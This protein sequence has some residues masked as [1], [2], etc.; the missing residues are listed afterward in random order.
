MLLFILGVYR[1]LVPPVVTIASLSPSPG[2][3]RWHALVPGAAYRWVKKRRV[4]QSN[5]LHWCSS[6]YKFVSSDLGTQ[7]P[8][9]SVNSQP[10]LFPA[11]FAGSCFKSSSDRSHSSCRDISKQGLQGSPVRELVT[12]DPMACSIAGQPHNHPSGIIAHRQIWQLLP[13]LKHGHV[14]SIDQLAQYHTQI[15]T[16]TEWRHQFCSGETRFNRYA[17]YPKWVAFRFGKPK[18]QSCSVEYLSFLILIL[19]LIRW[20]PIRHAFNH[21]MEGISPPVFQFPPLTSEGV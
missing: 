11:P 21:R 19:N 2:E 12:G 9:V 3:K 15:D 13:R 20:Y 10:V 8:S 4:A 6:H 17:V 1:V 16:P 7:V 14:E 18:K 5:D